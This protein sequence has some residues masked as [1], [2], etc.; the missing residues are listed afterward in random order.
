MSNLFWL[1]KDQMARVRPFLPKS[2]DKQ[3]VDFRRVLNGINF[4]N[5]N[6]LR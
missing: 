3:R 1:N 6:G 5:R 2:L 4:I